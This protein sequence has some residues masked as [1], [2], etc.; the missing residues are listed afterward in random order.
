MKMDLSLYLVTDRSMSKGRSI[1]YVVEEAVAGGVTIVQL[2]EKDASTREFVLLAQLLKRILEPYK[3]PLIINDRIDVAL[4]S[5]A[6]G[7]HI[8]QSDMPYPIARKLLGKNKI[9]GISVENIDDVR[10]S[11]QTDVDY[12][13][14]SPVFSTGTKT[15]TQKPFGLSGIR[16]VMTITRHPTVA[17]GGIC[18]TNAKEIMEA[19]VHGISVVSAIMAADDP[20]K[21]AEDLKKI[22]FEKLKQR[23]Y[24]NEKV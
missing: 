20:R 3:V 9:I 19:G 5:D 6:E 22:V 12:I 18:I 16:E 8:G 1:G 23:K 4:A 10:K 13:A 24:K 17:I 21:S 15:N 11:N 14:I 7:L 2:R